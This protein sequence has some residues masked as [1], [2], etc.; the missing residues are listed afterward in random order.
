MDLS[1]RKHKVMKN[2]RNG[3]NIEVRNKLKI[4]LWRPMVNEVS[5]QVWDQVNNQENEQP[6]N[7]LWVSEDRMSN[8]I[9]SQIYNPMMQNIKL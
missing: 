2:K 6:G 5:N 9:F 7:R 4:L 8:S 3:V 1:K